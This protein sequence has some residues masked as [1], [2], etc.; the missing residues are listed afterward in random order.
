M[1]NLHPM[2]DNSVTHSLTSLLCVVLGLQ[3]SVLHCKLCESW[4]MTLANIAGP[5]L[6]PIGIAFHYHF[7]PATFVV[8]MG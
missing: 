5:F 4:S 1:M 6:T 8:V 3:A 7:L 2:H